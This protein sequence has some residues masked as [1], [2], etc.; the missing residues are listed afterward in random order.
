MD[1]EL[2][3]CDTQD[4]VVGG[5]ADEFL[6]VGRLDNLCSSYCSLRALIDTCDSA[7]ALASEDRIRAIALFDHEEVG[8]S[9]AQGAGGPVMRDT[10][11]RVTKTL[12]KGEVDAVE[13]CLAASF[14]VSADMAHAKHPNYM[15]KYDP[16]QSPMIHDG[17]VVKTN[18]NQR[19]ASNLVSAA[20]FMCVLFSL[21][22]GGGSCA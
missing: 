2:Q 10:I 11:T 1:F 6:F 9:S 13:R 17:L 12:S 4:G 3:L 21:S 18:V 16:H 8:S 5:A 19:Y 7:D 22:D 20:L 15:E 14:L